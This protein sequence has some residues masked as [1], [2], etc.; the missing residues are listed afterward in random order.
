MPT[1]G[2]R[3]RKGGVVLGEGYGSEAWLVLMTRFRKG[4]G[5]GVY[6]VCVGR[7]SGAC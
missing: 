3:M 2:L 6:R 5:S 7:Y 4:N 1:E